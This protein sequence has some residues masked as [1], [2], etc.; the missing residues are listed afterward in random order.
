MVFQN[1]QL[2]YQNF[3][4]GPTPGRIYSIDHTTSSMIVKSY[5]GGDIVSTLIAT[6]P[7][8]LPIQNEVL[9][10]EF[11]GLYFWTLSSLSNN[12]GITINKWKIEGSEL[13]QKNIS[14]NAAIQ[15]QSIPGYITYNS[16]AFAV[17][18]Y[19]TYLAFAAEDTATSIIVNDATYFTLGDVIYIGPPYQGDFV[20][21]KI[22]T[23]IT[24]NTIHFDGQVGTHYYSNDL[25]ICRKNIWIFNNYA[26]MQETGNL[27]EFNSRTGEQVSSS[28]SNEWRSVSAATSYSHTI[29]FIKDSQVLEY[30]PF[31]LNKGYQSSAFI[32]NIRVD[33][34][35]TIK[36]VDIALDSGFLSKLQDKRHR[37]DV[38]TSTWKDEVS[39]GG[40]YEIE[41]NQIAPKV[42]SLSI[43]RLGPSV[44]LGSQATTDLRVNVRD[45]YDTPR[46]GVSIS[47]TEDD[48]TGS[49]TNI[50]G[51]TTD[52]KG[53]V[54]VRYNTNN[55]PDFSNPLI[56]II[57][58]S[59]QYKESSRLEQ[60]SNVKGTKSLDQ[61]TKIYGNSSINQVKTANTRRLDLI[62]TIN[63]STTVTQADWKSITVVVQDLAIN[64]L[65]IQQAILAT[66]TTPLD[67]SKPIESSATVVQF[68]FLIDAIP[69]PYSIKNVVDTNIM[70]RLLGY[71]I[72]TPLDANTIVMKVN[73]VDVSN[74]VIVTL[75]QGGLQIDYDPPENF[76][77]SSRT[78]VYISIR[79]TSF[80]VRTFSTSYYFDMVGDYKS[81]ILIKLY[82][83][84]KSIENLSTTEVYAIIKDLETGI[85]IDSIKLY[86]DGRVVN[87]TVEELEDSS[88]K[89]LFNNVC[90][91]IN[92]SEVFSTIYAEDLEGNKLIGPWSFFI[93]HSQGVLFTT[94]VPERCEYLVPI[95]T[96]ICGGAFGLEDGIN[97]DTLKLSV[98]DREVKYAITTKVY[99]KE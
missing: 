81:P 24:G 99:R 67:Q 19:R 68:Y 34:T 87:H 42:T 56:S 54:R 76:K 37:Y 84:N 57:D 3:S 75:F 9:E 27:I 65:P 92:E 83:P 55:L 28:T 94:I 47:V 43:E 71:N 45:Q 50:S 97:L 48:L 63:N 58:V 8:S 52:I 12:Y 6:L 39:I 78:N 74:R 86:I 29:T 22:I 11:D 17:H 15:L 44:L 2:A 4:F 79:D 98:K 26:G 70:I 41:Q 73:E 62:S 36:T 13:I 93:N 14:L 40:F 49:I 10:L 95:D 23:G 38:T 89:V 82:P 96:L 21:E 59:S 25:V 53:Q 72:A 32:G 16:E 46:L 1:V 35:T 5:A 64:T 60:K 91:Y 30:K 66:D 88:Y 31:G 85:N 61:V 18:R 20:T 77:Y 80:P 69:V 33:H 90:P 51:S 7:L